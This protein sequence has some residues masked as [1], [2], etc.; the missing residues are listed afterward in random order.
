MVEFDD[1]KQ[2]YQQ[3]LRSFNFDQDKDE[4]SAILLSE[5]MQSPF[6]NISELE[7][8]LYGRHVY[9]FGAHESVEAGIQFILEEQ[10]KGIFLAAD[11]AI[12]PML[13]NG[14][15]PDLILSD[16]DGNAEDLKYF[17][18]KGVPIIIHAHGDNL[19][20]VQRYGGQF[21]H[22]MGSTQSQPFGH[23]Q[24]FGGFTD[25]D[26]CVFTADHF[27]ALTITLVGFQFDTVGSFSFST[28]PE[29]KLQKLSW[30]KKLISLFEVEYL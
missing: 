8:L 17:N 9:I 26:R 15:Q 20:L 21:K 13:K 5:V 2:Y 25:G 4:Q 3:I 28:M 11:G 24:N 10:I 30:A 29:L 27:G 1:W 22:S 7:D 6:L 23:I 12:T 16:L 14:L 19:D 18:S